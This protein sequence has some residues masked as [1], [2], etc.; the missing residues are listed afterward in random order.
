M[1]MQSAC[2]MK[3]TLGATLNA[4]GIYG[5]RLNVAASST[6]NLP[7]ATTPSSP[8]CPDANSTV[9]SASNGAEFVIECG[10]VRIDNTFSVGKVSA[11]LF[12]LLYRIV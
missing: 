5:A 1:E 2:Y 7:A 10:I 3:G 6:S 12:F 4:K 8:T 9:F 11:L